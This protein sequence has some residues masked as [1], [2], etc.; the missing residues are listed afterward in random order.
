MPVRYTSDKKGPKQGVPYDA[1]QTIMDGKG[2]WWEG[3]DPVDLYGP[4]HNNKDPLL[5]PFANQFMWRVDDA[6]TKYHPDVIYFDEHAGDS[7]MDLGVRMGLG[8]LAP[9]L[10]ANYYNKSLK[11]NQ[12]K[13]EVV[14]NLKGVGGR[15]DSFQNSPE[16]LPYVDRSLVKSTEAIIESQIMAYPFQ[17]E[18][19][20]TDW[21]Y[22]V[23]QRY[24]DARSVI[25]SLMQN[26]SRNG[27]ML[28]NI[29]QH[30]RG[31]LDPEVVRIC[32][33][34]GAWLKV[35]G[36]AVYASR[37]FEVFGDNT[38]CYT[39]NQGRV[40][41]TLLDWQGGPTTLKALRSG[42]GTLGKV[43]KVELLGSDLAMTFVQDDQGLTVTPGGSAE[44]LPG[45]ANQRLASGC[46]VLRITH[47]KGWFNDDDPG[48]VAT[49]W[50][51][52]C[53]VGA[54][55]FNNDLTTSDTPGDVWRYSFTG[56][57]VSVIAPKEAGAGRIEVQID[58]ETRATVD[59]STTGTRQAQ[60]DVCEVTDLTQG[61]HVINIVNRGPGP[62][63][64]DAIV[65]Q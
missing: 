28:L 46:R 29:T 22:R 45:I 56:S 33:D 63:T 58:S 32:K 55:D 9:P 12:G 30:G 25:R 37:P 8:F 36:E 16:L 42:G 15:Y 31:D 11:W 48:A 47:D 61:K 6:I 34:I 51:R 17:T 21:H 38:V 19:S 5:S 20:I 54:G 27:T 35:N 65:V 53:N 49:G 39:R 59:L 3:M 43:S 14:I 41:A 7:Q 40:Y 10:I 60:Q 44:P 23:G 52:R 2:K 50:I 13:M 24:M 26:V 57:N 1:L 18:T 62:V 64:V 4:V